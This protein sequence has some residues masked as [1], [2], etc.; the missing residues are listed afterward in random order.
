MIVRHR[1]GY[2]GVTIVATALMVMSACANEPETESGESTETGATGPTSEACLAEQ[3]ATSCEAL[4]CRWHDTLAVEANACTTSAGTGRCFALEGQPVG[5]A[6]E[7]RAYYRTQAG[8]CSRVVGCRPAPSQ[9]L[10]S[11]SWSGDP[12]KGDQAVPI[13]ELTRRD[14][15]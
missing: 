1:L 6:S 9:P 13:R 7:P 5:Q 10:R 12:S 11:L 8:E 15:L 3:N 14:E 4:G 2:T